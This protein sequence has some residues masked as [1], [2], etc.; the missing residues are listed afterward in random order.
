[1][2]YI[3]ESTKGMEEVPFNK[4]VDFNKNGTVAANKDKVYAKMV[5]SQ[6]DKLYFIKTH[7]NQPFDPN[8]PFGSKMF[9]SNIFIKLLLCCEVRELHLP[10]LVLL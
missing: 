5:E 6:K 7:Q 3:N 4:E 8:N 10:D 1:M 2:K 9:L